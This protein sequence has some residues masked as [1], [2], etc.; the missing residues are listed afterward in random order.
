ML[1]LTEHK[2]PK[3]MRVIVCKER[4]NPA[5]QLRITDVDGH[6][7]TAFATNTATGGPGT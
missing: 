6:R 4:P 7:I 3:D 5:A 2:S 1:D